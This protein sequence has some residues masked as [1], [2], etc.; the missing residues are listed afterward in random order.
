[1]S[2]TF[3]DAERGVRA[4]NPSP[5]QRDLVEE[6]MRHGSEEGEILARYESLKGDVESPAARYLVDFIVVDSRPRRR[7]RHGSRPAGISA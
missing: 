7:H 6:F 3:S 2:Q 1:M 4:T 5:D